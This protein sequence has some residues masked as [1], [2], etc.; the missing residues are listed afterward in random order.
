MHRRQPSES[1]EGNRAFGRFMGNENIKTLRL[2]YLEYAGIPT[3]VAS[4]PEIPVTEPSKNK[5]SDS[6]AGENSAVTIKFQTCQP[7][8]DVR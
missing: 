3:V 8:R 5:P 6:P 4:A 1:Y 7:R 2:T